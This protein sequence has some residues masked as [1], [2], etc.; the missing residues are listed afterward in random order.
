MKLTV[1]HEEGPRFRVETGGNTACADQPV[2]KDGTGK[3]L[4]APECLVASRGSCV[5]VC[6]RDFAATR[7]IPHEG[8]RVDVEWA[9]AET[10][11]RISK[12][13]IR[14]HIPAEIPER[15]RDPSIRAAEQCLVHNTLRIAPQVSITLAEG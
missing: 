9:R 11:T 12:I 5:G 8:F 3:G 10:P 15:Y 7:N 1:T 14:L 13:D 6:V 2:E 4:S